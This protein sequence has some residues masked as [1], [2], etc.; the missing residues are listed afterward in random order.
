MLIDKVVLATRNPGKLREFRRLLQ[1]FGCGLVGL[2][3]IAISWDHAE[4]GASFAENA[5]MKA[6]A[7]SA[8]TDMEVLADDSGLEVAAL[9]GRP[10]ICSARYA[11][12]GAA[13]GERV[14]KLLEELRDVPPPRHAHFACALALAQRGR[15]L[16]EAEGECPGE[17][18]FEPRGNSG[19]GY[20]PIFIVPA[21]ARTFAELGE[22]EKNRISHRARAVNTLFR[23]ARR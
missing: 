21:L 16:L 4:T 18:G 22:D 13:D 11:G 20:D 1:P 8:G 9:G 2:Q 17:I 23:L 10:G 5:R 6:I 14:Q 12:P 7:Y 19:F 15:L 3:E